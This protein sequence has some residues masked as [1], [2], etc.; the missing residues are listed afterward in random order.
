MKS[1]LL[2]IAIC[3]C[4]LEPAPAD[5]FAVTNTQDSGTGSL[6]EAVLAANSH[7]GPDDIVFAGVTGIITLTTSLPTITDDVTIVGPGAADLTVSGGGAI[8]IATIAAGKTVQIS[9]CTFANGKA[10]N[11]ANGAA[12]ENRG[13]LT[14]SACAFSNNQTTGGWGGAI[15]NDG[16]L[17]LI[18]TAFSGNIANGERGFGG[19]P[20]A[21]NP[22][23]GG[24]SGGGGAG[25]GGAIYSAAGSV[26][27]TDCTFTGN[28]A[29]GG[30]ISNP[31]GGGPPGLT[32]LGGRGGGPSGGAPGAPGGFGSGG[33]GGSWNGGGRGTNGGAGG[34]GGSGGAGGRGPQ[35]GFNGPILDG[36]PGAG[37]YGSGNG[38][39]GFGSAVFVKEGNCSLTL[40]SF[41]QNEAR[42]G[43]GM[44]AL[45][46]YAGDVVVEDC[47][48]SANV[49]L[50]SNGVGVGQGIGSYQLGAG[51]AQGGAILNYGGNL[52]LSRSTI[53][54]CQAIGGSGGTPNR[55]GGFAGSAF[56]GGVACV[57]GSTTM[58][59]VT[60]SQNVASGG[61]ASDGTL[62]STG[63]PGAA[64]GGALAVMG[65]SVA[66]TNCSVAFNRVQPGTRAPFI[67]GLGGPPSPGEGSGG[68]V[69]TNGAAPSLKNNLFSG[70]LE[71]WSTT[72]TADDGSGTVSSQGHNLFTADAGVTGLVASDLRNVAAPL[73]PLQDN[74]GPTQTHALP[75]GS[76]AIDAGD[77]SGAPITDQRGVIRPQGI[78]EDIGAYE[79]APLAILIDGVGAPSGRVVRNSTVTVSMQ[80]EFPTGGIFYTLDGST[81]TLASTP[82]AGPFTLPNSTTIRAIAYNSDF[83]SSVFAGPVNFILGIPRTL[84]VTTSGPGTV[85][86]NPFNNGPYLDGT[87]V[88]LTATPAAGYRFQGW[89]G[90][91]SGNTSPATLTMIADRAV[92]A[93]FVP[94][95]LS[96][97]KVGAGTVTLSPPGG[98]YPLNTTVSLTATPAFGWAFQ[99]WSGDL[100]GTTSP[101]TLTMTGDRAVTATFVALPTHT[102]SVTKVG[103]GT[104]TLNPPGGTYPLN[105][106][107]SLTATPAAGWMFQGW[108]GDLSGTASPATLTMTGERAVTATFVRVYTVSITKIGQGTVTLTPTG[109]TYPPNTTVFVR[110]TAAAGWMFQGWS[111]D[112]SGSATIA[113]L[114]M[115][116]DR[117][118]TAT[119]VPIYTVSIAKTGQGT[120]TLS[121]AGGTYAANSTVSLTATPAAGWMFH[122]WSGD[123]S[124]NVTPASL[125]MSGNRSVTAT[126][127]E[128]PPYRVSITTTGDGIVMLTPSAD[129]YSSNS[130][131]SAEP[132]PA[133]GW[134]FS[135]WSG[136]A[137]GTDS[138]LEVTM[139][140]HKALHATFTK[141]FWLTTTTRGGGTVAVTPP[142]AFHVIGTAVNVTA[143]PSA[144][145][146]FMRWS[147]DLENISASN[148]IQAAVRNRN[149][150]AIFGTPLSVGVVGNGTVIRK[151][152]FPLYRAQSVV[153]LTAVPEIGNYF[154]S[155]T[156]PFGNRVNPLDLR[157][158]T[159]NPSLSAIFAPLAQNE[160]A[161]T[162]VVDGAGSVNINPPDTHF[163]NGTTVQLLAKPAFG[164]SFLGWSGDAVGG[165]AALSVLVDSSKVITARFSKQPELSVT[166]DIGLIRTEGARLVLRGEVGS[167]YQILAAPTP[168]GQYAPIGT[169]Y[170][171][172]GDVKFV[173]GTATVLG[174]RFYRVLV[175]P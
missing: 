95:T 131:V 113:P 120:V 89:S 105:T 49:A 37:G 107:V 175:L 46:I 119:F 40:S 36:S 11:Y 85:S 35:D 122:G 43:T 87:V 13:S 47:T 93:T 32:G 115:S 154:S 143:N 160:S 136:A 12:I 145:W 92:T 126:F 7:P 63:Y 30:A 150:E 162:V 21:A 55:W 100:S 149:V 168:M 166:P 72:D 130:V 39:A 20:A 109:G 14:V 153:R 135:G 3:L 173:D 101:A 103:E 77:N 41:L 50:G 33:G 116:E 23:Y 74:G 70:N 132:I 134:I 170:N 59:N 67:G 142:S 164:Q 34:F 22:N 79:S 73:E 10:T 38:G 163:Q 114:L 45:F 151:P 128:I 169:V 174:Q 138:P 68:G 31:S 58:T 78:K 84:T 80:A 137:T 167:T 161:L 172:L 71:R 75:I 17:T 52:Q 64:R 125:L 6:R 8:Q 24:G 124:G 129:D 86:V 90:D 76:P 60:L 19:T 44:G 127:V 81:P 57:G 4:L 16:N 104:V 51:I 152:D 108:S 141:I 82:Y 28:G 69:Y 97:S 133:T 118:V 25:L 27:V 111:G 156:N 147:G 42:G 144:G 171:A 88:T 1:L 112:L 148:N 165:N 146:Q 117:S 66:M 98:A 48:F 26:A 62:L 99:G 123:L 157:I 54:F 102:L 5:T 158:T 65:G 155:W 94:Y 159:A 29:R 140:G 96:V 56:G 2:S 110:A 9:G 61:N 83:T 106:P 91:L 18:D 53:A 121:P 139:N 15:F